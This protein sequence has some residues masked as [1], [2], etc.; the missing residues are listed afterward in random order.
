MREIKEKG[1]LDE[2]YKR[3]GVLKNFNN[4]LKK[5]VIWKKIN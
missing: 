2:H 3:S 4:P 5:G 1:K